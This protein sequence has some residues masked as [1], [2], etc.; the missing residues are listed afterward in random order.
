VEVGG[1]GGGGYA[2]GGEEDEGK[3]EDDEEVSREEGEEARS[4]REGGMEWLS[5]SAFSNCGDRASKVRKDGR[6]G[7]AGKGGVIVTSNFALPISLLIFGSTRSDFT[8]NPTRSDFTFNSTCSISTDAGGAEDDED[9]D[10]NDDTGDDED[11]V[12]DDGDG[13][14]SR[15]RKKEWSMVCGGFLT[16]I[17]TLWPNASVPW[18]V[19]SSRLRCLFMKYSRQRLSEAAA[20]G[21]CMRLRIQCASHC[22]SKPFF[23]CAPLSVCPLFL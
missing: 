5:C 18:R 4:G 7:S 16:L 19:A 10:D 23:L 20:E 21:R 9:E 6:G 11:D 2:R 12:G 22:P 14:G 17:P 3:E 1:N 15:R 13:D 8:F